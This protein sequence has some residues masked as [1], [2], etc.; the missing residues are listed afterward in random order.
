MPKQTKTLLIQL[1]LFILTV[2]TTSIVGAE[3]MNFETAKLL[4]SGKEITD[5]FWL[6]VS[7]GL[8][9][10]IPF[11]GVL[12]VHEFG[13]YFMAKYHKLKV[14]LPYYIPIWLP[15]VF[16]FGTMGAVIKL[17]SVTQSKLQFFDVGIAGPLAGFVAALL[18]LWYGFTHLP[19]YDAITQI[20]P[21]YAQH[22]AQHGADYAEYA[23]NSSKKEGMI[24]LSFGDNLLF[25]LFK[26]YVAPNPADV[27]A[28]FE[29]MHY[30]FLMAGYLALFF[31]ALNLLP[32]GQLDGGHILYGLF[33]KK[34]SDI[35]STWIFT[36]FVTWAGIGFLSPY[37]PQD[38]LMWRVP[39]Y[40]AFMYVLFT[41][42]FESKTTAL[43]FGLGVFAFQFI[44]AFLFQG[45][46]GYNG[47]L[48]FALII[49]KVLGT[50]H[51]Q[52]LIEDPLD[53]K[54]KTLGWIALVI[55]VLCFSPRPFM[56]ELF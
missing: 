6:F 5:N 16:S 52:A 31:T 9:Y 41:S 21:E 30:P 18:V 2:F 17:K 43:T 36:A 44:V 56:V 11:L 40:G 46:E 15:G 50:K 35:I 1:L 12:T 38:E 26:N 8:Y 3:Y 7:T 28:S 10:S 24:I 20:H 47:W 54:R 29:M 49:S 19:A 22:I 23:L 32:I 4:N 42:V 33:G 34:K 48:V 45:F 39:L 37:T 51:P 13:H 14:T 55:F 27:P 53:T 25:W